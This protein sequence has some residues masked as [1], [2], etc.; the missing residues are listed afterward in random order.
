MKTETTEQFWN[1]RARTLVGRTI[2]D[3][4][5][6]TDEEMEQ[7]GWYKKSLVIF[8]D[9]GEYLIP[10]RDDEGNDAGSLHGS[11]DKLDFPTV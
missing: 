11:S 5:Y 3:A 6:M 2:V 8:F 10:M 7:F 9:N 1:K 4:R